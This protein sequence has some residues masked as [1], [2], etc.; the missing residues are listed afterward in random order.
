[1]KLKGIWEKLEE[2]KEFDQNI[3]H[4]ILNKNKRRR[5]K[6]AV[7]HKLRSQRSE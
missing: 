6:K 3:L 5:R 7:A 4:E 1:M 2:R